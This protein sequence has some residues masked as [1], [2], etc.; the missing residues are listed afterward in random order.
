MNFTDRVL[1]RCSSDCTPEEIH[2][3]ALKLL[4]SEMLSL[5]TEM[6]KAKDSDLNGRPLSEAVTCAE[7]AY[8][9]LCEVGGKGTLDF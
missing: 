5:I 4:K 8:L 1:A 3:A 2:A 9:W 6:R 7:T